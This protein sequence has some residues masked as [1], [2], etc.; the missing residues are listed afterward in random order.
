MSATT[1]TQNM[2]LSTAL[3]VAKIHEKG[4]SSVIRKIQIYEKLRIIKE[5]QFSKTFEGFWDVGFFWLNKNGEFK[6]H[7]KLNPARHINDCF[8]YII[9]IVKDYGLPDAFI[10]A[11]RL[12]A[13]P[14]DHIEFNGNSFKL[15]FPQSDKNHEWKDFFRNLR[16]ITGDFAEINRKLDILRDLDILVSFSVN[17]A[18]ISLH[19]H[20]DSDPNN[21]LVQNHTVVKRYEFGYD[22]TTELDGYNCYE[23]I[24]KDIMD[25]ISC[26]AKKVAQLAFD[27]VITNIKMCVRENSRVMGIPTTRHI[28]FHLDG[29]K[30]QTC[31]IRYNWGQKFYLGALY[32][33]M[34]DIINGE[35]DHSLSIPSS[36][37]DIF[38]PKNLPHIQFGH[39]FDNECIHEI[40][41]VPK[42]TDTHLYR[43][44]DGIWREETDGE[45]HLTTR[46]FI[47]VTEDDFGLNPWVGVACRFIKTCDPTKHYIILANCDV[48]DTEHPAVTLYKNLTK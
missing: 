31:E 5:L 20:L 33:S 44:I 17:K 27:D 12:C 29:Q 35:K 4:L 19:I 34:L 6:Y 21:L 26:N 37:S 39:T 30:F 9:K 25:K 24:L 18:E 43:D 28:E 7:S 15:V 14:D 10:V 41:V 1:S 46:L 3:T 32:N 45:T 23:N 42:A 11:Q 8:D 47:S 16:F 48:N 38:I 40:I 36:S 13:L 2:T 22:S